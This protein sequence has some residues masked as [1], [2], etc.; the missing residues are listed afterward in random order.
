MKNSFGYKKL[1][2]EYNLTFQMS[3]NYKILQI[4]WLG[5]LHAWLKGLFPLSWPIMR[6]FSM[7][8]FAKLFYVYRTSIQQHLCW[9]GSEESPS[10]LFPMQRQAFI[11]ALIF[12]TFCSYETLTLTVN[13]ELFTRVNILSIAPRYHIWIYVAISYRFTIAYTRHLDIAMYIKCTS[14]KRHPRFVK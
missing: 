9:Q 4:H 6:L 2:K 1:M 5:N 3:E 8:D 7:S 11:E 10:Y 13:Y 12:N 14:V